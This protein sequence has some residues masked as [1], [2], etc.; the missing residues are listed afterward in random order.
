MFPL[1]F[2]MH[3]YPIPTRYY[4]FISTCAYRSNSGD[5]GA[6][7]QAG[8]YKR[9]YHGHAPS[10][11][12]PCMLARRGARTVRTRSEPESERKWARARLVVL[13]SVFMTRLFADIMSTRPFGPL[14]LER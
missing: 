6:K 12:G 3:Y 1:V 10:G 14:T 7:K 2:T 4:T 11:S 9:G 5:M 13:L 8:A